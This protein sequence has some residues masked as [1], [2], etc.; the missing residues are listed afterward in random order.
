MQGIG[1]GFGLS[2]ASA[3]ASDIYRGKKL[4]QSLSLI[5]IIYAVMPVLAP[6]IG[7]TLQTLLNWRASFWLLF[8]SGIFMFGF[9]F[10]HFVETKSNLTQKRPPVIEIISLYKQ[11]LKSKLF[12][13][14]FA[15]L[16]LF[17]TGEVGYI[18]QMPLIA[19]K[20]F[21]VT[22]FLT[23]WLV[24]FTSLAIIIGSSLSMYLLKKFKPITLV[25]LGVL[26]AVLSVIMSFLFILYDQYTLLTLIAPMTLFMMGSGLAFPNAMGIYLDCFPE[27]TGATSSLV[28]GGLTAVGGLFT[29]VIAKLPVHLAHA[30][31]GFLGA[32]VILMIFALFLLNR[33]CKK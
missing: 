33:S 2:I 30:L 10:S 21:V 13:A 1:L 31:P 32:I 28:I 3:V 27:H 5:S 11:F 24:L 26:C 23:G 16:T 7:G 22:P 18:I 15:I 12:V 25:N 20:I 6:V 29:I 4:Y 9:A 19:Q 8:I 14:N 17:Y